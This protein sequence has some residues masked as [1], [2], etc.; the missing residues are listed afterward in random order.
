MKT[1][2]VI[3]ALGVLALLAAGCGSK[4]PLSAEEY[5]ALA[6]G[7]LREGAYNVAA[8]QYRELLDQYPF[9]QYSQEAE[10]KI[11]HA[12]FLD[13]RCPEAVA[14]LTDFQR[15]HPTSPSLPFVG[16][17]LGRCYE[18][19]MKPPDRDQ[20]ASQ[21][22]YAYYT[23]VVQQY[24]DSP[25]ADLARQRLQHCREVMAE[26]EMIVANFYDSHDN[27]K[28]AETRLLDLVNQFNDTDVAGDALYALG[29]L[30]RREGEPDKAVLAY[31]AVTRDHPDN[32]IAKKAERALDRLATKDDLPPG[33]P[34]VALIAQTGRSRT[35]S[36]A[37]VTE[38]PEPAPARG[39]GLPPT[40]FGLPQSS[41]PFGRTY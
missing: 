33:D 38:L 10:L 29:N 6:S 21:N 12:Q 13:G 41:G 2:H 31:A 34:L 40:G 1:N 23:A 15:R 19:Q 28:A 26:H 24:P 18:L 37:K 39:G 4:K 8:E 16:Y 7:N 25:F 35:L 17:L 36:I 11:A 5:F 9:S 22:A 27:R 3:P 30:Y 20:S 32:G 14:A